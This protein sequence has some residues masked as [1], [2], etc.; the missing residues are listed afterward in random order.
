MYLNL[1]N[2]FHEFLKIYEGLR[3]NIKYTLKIII[4]MKILNVS[5]HEF[6]AQI[7][8]EILIYKI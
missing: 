6:E 8:A 5:D 2:G 1:L 4:N 3:Y 7:S